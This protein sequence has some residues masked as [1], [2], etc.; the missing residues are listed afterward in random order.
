[1]TFQLVLGCFHTSLTTSCLRAFVGI[2][3]VRRL[4]NMGCLPDDAVDARAIPDDVLGELGLTAE[5]VG[6]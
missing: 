3:F 4:R 5:E 2:C 1:M 6:Q